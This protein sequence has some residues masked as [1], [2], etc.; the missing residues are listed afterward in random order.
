MRYLLL[1]CGVLS[2]CAAQVWQPPRTEMVFR[3]M[4]QELRRAQQNLRSEGAPAPYYIEYRL[5]YRAALV[6]QA[7]LGELV[8]SNESQRATLTVAVRIGTPELDNTN[9]AAPSFLL[10][11][12]ASPRET[13]RQ[14]T[15]PIELSDTLLRRELWLAT[16]AA[17]KDAVEQYGR[18]LNILRSQLRRDTT[19]DFRLLPA[20]ELFDTLA[21]STFPRALAERLCR[22]LSA[23]FRQYPEFT[24]SAVSFEY[25]PTQ[26]WYANTEGRRAVKTELFTGLEVVAY[27]QANDGTLLAQYYSAYARTPAELPSLDSLRQAV[28]EVAQRL[29]AQRSASALEETYVGPVLFEGRAAGELI[30]QVLVPQLLLHRE[31]LSDAPVFTTRAQGLARRIG[32]RILPEFLSLRAAPCQRW[33]RQTPLVGSYCVD[34][35]GVRAN[36]VQ[37]VEKGVLRQLLSTRV[38][39]R[40]LARSNG[41]NR[42]G[43]PMVGVLELIPGEGSGSVLERQQLR[44]YF[45]QL[46]RQRELPYGILV[47]SVMNLNIAQTVLARA[48]LGKYPSFAREGS[49][50]IVAAFRVYPDGREELLQPCDAVGITVR[51]LRDILAVSREQTPYNYLAPAAAAGSEVPYLPVSIVTPDIVLEEVEVRPREGSVPKPPLVSPP[52]IE[53]R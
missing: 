16:D 28:T 47:R 45:L 53:R 34:D 37:V 9:L 6:A 48:S 21:V 13:Y 7:V 31:P 10:F 5:Q 22:E 3:A 51:S 24:A 43:A 41:H 46:L 25:L 20:E 19:P 40:W 12:G 14:R 38:P 52:F 1:L 2:V 30:A 39:T 49:L 29:R 42:A 18:K 33:F 26:T 15:I 17:Y 11:G 8:E 44:Q 50:P 27:A 4:E 23:I 36:T 32:S 35:E